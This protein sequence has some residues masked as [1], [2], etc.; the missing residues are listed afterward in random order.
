MKKTERIIAVEDFM[1]VRNVNF[2]QFYDIRIGEYQ[3]TL[4]GKF[5]SDITKKLMP[6]VTFALTDYGYLVGELNIPIEG[7]EESV[8]VRIVLT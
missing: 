3:I 8:S 5:D 1:S 4:Q 7:S 2:D 6:V